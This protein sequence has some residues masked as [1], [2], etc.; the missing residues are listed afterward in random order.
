MFRRK[1]GS[2]A[3]P[4][5]PPPPANDPVDF[6][7]DEF[8]ETW[9]CWREACGDVRTAYLR[10]AQSDAE[11]RELAFAGYRAA[12]DREDQAA[13]VYSIWTERLRAAKTALRGH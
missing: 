1:R 4:D 6:V 9:I 5:A 7:V 3:D 12:L 13:R 2:L 10:W 8:L 11:Q